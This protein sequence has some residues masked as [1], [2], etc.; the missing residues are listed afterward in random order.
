MTM[1]INGQGPE[2]KAM[3]MQM[4]LAAKHKGECTGKEDMKA[5]AP[6]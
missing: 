4:A 3:S 1:S 5:G 6:G 2:G